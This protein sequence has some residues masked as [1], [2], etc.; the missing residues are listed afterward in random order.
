MAA[1]SLVLVVATA[2][3]APSRTALFTRSPIMRNRPYSKMLGLRPARLSAIK[4]SCYADPREAATRKGTAKLAAAGLAEA[5]ACAN[6][7]K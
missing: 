3:R 2:W 4:G 6:A 7:T 5:T 1:V